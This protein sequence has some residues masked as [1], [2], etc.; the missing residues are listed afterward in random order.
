MN[1]KI[2][3]A[4]ALIKSERFELIAAGDTSGGSRAAK[5]IFPSKKAY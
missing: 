5:F 3:G 4:E 1:I 2:M